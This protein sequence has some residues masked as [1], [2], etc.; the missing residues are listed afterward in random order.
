MGHTSAMT[1]VKD[2]QGVIA[3]A[4]WPVELSV[5]M[6]KDSLLVEATEASTVPVGNLNECLCNDVA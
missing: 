2:F 5:S 3:R 6:A 1:R 4:S